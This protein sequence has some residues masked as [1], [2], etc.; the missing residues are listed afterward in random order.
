[1]SLLLPAAADLA[2]TAASFTHWSSTT[3]VGARIPTDR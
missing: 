1:M 2:Q 3:P